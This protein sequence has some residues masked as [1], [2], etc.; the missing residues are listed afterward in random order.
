[1]HTRAW[2]AT[3]LNRLRLCQPFNRDICPTL[4]RAGFRPRPRGH[5]LSDSLTTSDARAVHSLWAS[6]ERFSLGAPTRAVVSF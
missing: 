1:M 6:S 5:V 2:V 3:V 4:I